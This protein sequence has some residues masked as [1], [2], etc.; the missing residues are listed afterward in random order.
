MHKKF[1][2]FYNINLQKKI[3]IMITKLKLFYFL[4]KPSLPTAYKFHFLQKFF[5]NIDFGHL[6]LSIFQNPKKV[7]ETLKF[8]NYRQKGTFNTL[9]KT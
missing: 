1:R 2:H 5:S 8:F 3:K 6:F 4:L 9:S 7:L